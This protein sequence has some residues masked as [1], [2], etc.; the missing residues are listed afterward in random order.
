MIGPPNVSIRGG[1]ARSRLN[2]RVSQSGDVPPLH[3]IERA[4]E[5]SDFLEAV[6]SLDSIME[7]IKPD[8]LPTSKAERP[9]RV[10]KL[11]GVIVQS[12]RT[13][14]LGAWF[15]RPSKCWTCIWEA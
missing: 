11:N 7:A 4:F 13:S 9:G 2:S 5:L 12:D 3:R 15:I 6:I 1:G 10:V 14:W 8:S